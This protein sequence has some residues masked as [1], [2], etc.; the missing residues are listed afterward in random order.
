[1]KTKSAS[2]CNAPLCVFDAVPEFEE[3][4]AITQD[5]GIELA[6]LL[7]SIT[8]KMASDILSTSVNNRHVAPGR[9]VEYRRR[10]ERGEWV[11]AEPWLFDQNGYLIDGQHRATALAQ[12]KNHDIKIPVLL[13]QGWPDETQGAVDIGYNRTI[14]SI[15]QL[16]GVD[17]VNDHL[18][19]MNAMLLLSPDRTTTIKAPDLAIDA[20]K[21][22]KDRLDFAIMRRGGSASRFFAPVRAVV[23]TAYPYE[24]HQKLERFLTV[25][26]TMIAVNEVEQSVARLRSQYE[27]SDGGA[28]ASGG[29]FREKFAKRAI[30]VLCAFL[31]DRPISKIREKDCPWQTLRIVNGEVV[32]P[33]A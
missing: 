16:K 28:G 32:V 23:A 4:A 3:R 33:F 31:E 12:L 5:Q 17:M 9:V 29:A 8:P 2:I 27:Q 1:M 22:M 19:T 26:D 14:C 24:N 18:S 7:V 15:A 6:C 13:V 21:K 25:W 11:L 10:M 20:Y 30:S